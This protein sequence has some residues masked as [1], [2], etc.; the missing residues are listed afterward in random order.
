MAIDALAG[1]RLYGVVLVALD[2]GAEQA[3]LF[4]VGYARV[5][6]GLREAHRL[7]GARANGFSAAVDEHSLLSGFVVGARLAVESANNPEKRTEKVSWS[8]DFATVWAVLL[9]KC[10]LHGHL[11]V[12]V[13]AHALRFDEVFAVGLEMDHIQFEIRGGPVS[14]NV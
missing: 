7:G 13:R 14:F 12:A 9:V 6:H 8:F 1:G 2:G 11:N 4:A 3:Q 10:V 5:A